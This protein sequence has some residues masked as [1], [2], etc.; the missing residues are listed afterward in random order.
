[1]SSEN[2]QDFEVKY[3]N[4]ACGHVCVHLRAYMYICRRGREVMVCN[5]H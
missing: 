3:I 1:M 4:D 5:G 2:C